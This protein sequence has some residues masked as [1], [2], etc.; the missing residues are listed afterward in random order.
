MKTRRKMRLGLLI[1]AALMMSMMIS[2]AAAFADDEGGAEGSEG[3]VTAYNLWVGGIQVTDEN[4]E[5]V[6]GDGGSVKY[7]PAAEEKEPDVLTLTDADIEIGGQGTVSLAGIE[8]REEYHDLKIIL[9][10]ENTISSKRPADRGFGINVIMSSE[11]TIGGSGT[12]DIDMENRYSNYSCAIFA[13]GGICSLILDDQ[14]KVYITTAGDGIQTQCMALK[15]SNRFRISAVCDAVRFTYSYD[16]V[17]SLYISPNSS[18]EAFSSGD[19]EDWTALDGVK[20]ALKDGNLKD[21]QAFVGSSADALEASPWAWSEGSETPDLNSYKY[22]RFPY[23]EDAKATVSFAAG[24]NVDGEMAPATVFKGDRYILPKCGF[25]PNEGYVFSGW[26]VGN[27][28]AVRNAGEKVFIEDDTTITATWAGKPAAMDL[29]IGGVQVNENNM[30]DVLGDHTV[31]VTKDEESKEVI[32]TLENASLTAAVCDDGTD[33]G[34]SYGIR[35]DESGYDLKVVLNGKNKITSSYA[36][37]GTDKV[38]GIG[39]YQSDGHPEYNVT[40]TGTGSLEDNVDISRTRVT[41]YGIESTQNT[42]IDGTTV[43]IKMPRTSSNAY[44]TVKC[45]NNVGSNT[46][47]LTGNAN[48]SI[49]SAF[50]YGIDNSKNDNVDVAIEKGSTLYIH[51]ERGSYGVD[52][53]A[54]TKTGSNYTGDWRT[55][56]GNGW[57]KFSDDTIARGIMVKKTAQDG[58]ADW[59]GNYGD[60]LLCRYLL[61]HDHQLTGTDA[62]AATCTEDGNIAYWTCDVCGAVFSD[63]EGKTALEP[64]DT[65]V[66]AFGHKWNA[67]YKWNEDFSQVTATAVCENDKTHVANETV[68]TTLEVKDPTKYMEGEKK[69]TASFENPAFEVQVKTVTIPASAE[70]DDEIQAAALAKVAIDK[71]KAIKGDEYSK[72]SYAAVTQALDSLIAV[73]SDPEAAIEQVR[74][75]TETLNTAVSSLKK[76]QPMKIKAVKK[77]VKAKKVKKKARVV[78]GAVKFT[79]KAQGTVTYK[80]V[81]TSKKAKKALKINKKTGK[82]TVRKKTKKGTYKM[83]V[84]VTAAGNAQFEKGSQTLTVTVR[85]K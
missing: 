6:F 43:Q 69:Y 63:E 29:Y 12:L 16:W 50:A 37:E 52:W 23:A 35:Y 20:P 58:Y 64:E 45:Y 62:K 72:A 34:T 60:L 70:T 1:L 81:G 9:N 54:E 25:T 17:G 28:E 31:S 42:T 13:S 85:V 19:R 46:L 74:A 53:D 79:V 15:G 78:S 56:H 41:Y 77:T 27:E 24:D 14:A 48:F 10:G 51:A 2:A 36:D 33:P 4:K 47:S 18:F 7:T 21:L 32:L 68:E 71:A 55:V 57:V 83:K 66:K 11:V 65:V 84:T 8:Y 44:V 30:T 3:S 39:I 73:I 61:I 82:I 80:G 38:V 67:E 40:F 75:G 49:D 59:N 26:K 76:D 22:V 5:D